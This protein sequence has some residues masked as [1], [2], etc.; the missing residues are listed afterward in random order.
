MRQLSRKCVGLDVSQTFEPLW[1]VRRIALPFFLT[2]CNSCVS[3]HF[4]KWLRTGKHNLQETIYNI[5]ISWD[6]TQ[7]SL[8]VFET[9][10]EFDRF[11]R[12]VGKYLPDYMAT[13]RSQRHGNCKSHTVHNN[14]A[15]RDWLDL[16]LRHAMGASLCGRLPN[17]VYKLRMVCRRVIPLL[18]LLQVTSTDASVL[19]N[20]SL[21]HQLTR[22]EQERL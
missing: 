6:V 3:T 7:C 8:V 10:N 12:N 2:R 1:L 5:V 15:N 11:L 16:L 17:S 13:H 14:C 18:D 20:T 19:D 22:W 21:L 9:E 4:R